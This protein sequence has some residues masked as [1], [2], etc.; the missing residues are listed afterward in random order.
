[1]LLYSAEGGI[2]MSGFQIAQNGNKLDI[3]VIL[4]NWRY[5]KIVVNDD[6]SVD[7]KVP[8]GMK[9]EMIDRYLEVN[10]EQIFRDYETKKNRNHQSLPSILELENGRLIYRNG[11]YLPHL[12]NMDLRLRIRHVPE[13][14][15]TKVYLD[16]GPNGEKILTI[17]TDNTNQDFIRYCIMRYYKKKAASIVK[18]YVKDFSEKLGL[19]YRN[20]H[21]TNLSTGSRFELPRFGYSN[22]AVRDQRTLWGRCTRKHTLKFDWKLAML[23]IEVIQ[24]I[25]IHELTHVKKMNHSSAF[26]KEVEKIMPEYNECRR[27]LDRHGKEYEIF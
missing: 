13:G 6:L 1:M 17:R 15:E 16:Q 5:V 10:K 24:Y 14:E 7:M 20:V 22:L 21:I 19:S 23:P 4:G 26:W 2:L 3:H 12:G 25:I 18:H 27:W 11:Q 8:V 9:Q